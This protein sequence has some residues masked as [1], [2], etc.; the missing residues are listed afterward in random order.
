MV[1]ASTAVGRRRGGT[2]ALEA[3]SEAL[4]EPVLVAAG[5]EHGL[6]V[7]EGTVVAQ[8]SHERGERVHAVTVAPAGDAP[9]HVDVSSVSREMNV[10]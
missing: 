6:C 5:V 9:R 8:R 10:V 2:G 1:A 7:G 3:A 4:D